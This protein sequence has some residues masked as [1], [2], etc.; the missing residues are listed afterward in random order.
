MLG[1]G[2]R[3]ARA[4][5]STSDEEVALVGAAS[6]ALGDEGQRSPDLQHGCD[7]APPARE[8]GIGSLSA[9]ALLRSLDFITFV[10]IATVIFIVIILI[11]VR[12]HADRA[13]DHL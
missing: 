7:P 4:S 6:A 10:G 1:N 9:P 5:S 13:D 2:N 8:G 12:L 11:N 3:E